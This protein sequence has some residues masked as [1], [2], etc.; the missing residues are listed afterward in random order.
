LGREAVARLAGESPAR[1][2]TI[3]LAQIALDALD[4]DKVAS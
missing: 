4:V 1:R 2:G 3:V